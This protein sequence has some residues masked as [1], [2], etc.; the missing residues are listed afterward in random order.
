MNGLLSIAAN[1]VQNTQGNPILQS[2]KDTPLVR[3]YSTKDIMLGF[4]WKN[5]T[6]NRNLQET[7]QDIRKIPYILFDG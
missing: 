7:K 5:S 6:L 1:P 3:L 2:K 4:G